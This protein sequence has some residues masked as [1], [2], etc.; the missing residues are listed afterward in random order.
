MKATRCMSHLAKFYAAPFGSRRERA[1]Y[2]VIENSIDENTVFV[3]DDAYRARDCEWTGKT[4]DDVLVSA[5]TKG[6]NISRR[7]RGAYVREMQF[8]DEFCGVN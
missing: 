2:E 8:L 3:V 5:C 4:S 1:A 7:A 6:D